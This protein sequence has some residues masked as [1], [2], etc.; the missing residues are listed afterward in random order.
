M[1]NVPGKY[2]PISLKFLVLMALGTFLL[3]HGTAE[4]VK[5]NLNLRDY[6]HVWIMN[7]FVHK[8]KITVKQKDYI[9]KQMSIYKA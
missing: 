7:F 5:K 2:I 6:T 4:L 9:L 3:F 8:Y 1:P